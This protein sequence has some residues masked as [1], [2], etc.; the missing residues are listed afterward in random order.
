M[1]FV[2]HQ[3]LLWLD[4]SVDGR[5]LDCGTELER[6]WQRFYQMRLQTMHVP[7]W[8]DDPS[9]FWAATRRKREQR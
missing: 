1:P 3:P 4:L 2:L 9:Y 8:R 6:R 5:E 7:A